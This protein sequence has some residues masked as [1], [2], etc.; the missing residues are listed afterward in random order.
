MAGP[1][2]QDL[3]WLHPSA[4]LGQ[5][6]D[7]TL[8][9][10]ASPAAIHLVERPAQLPGALAALRASLHGP[11]PWVAIDLEWRTDPHGRRS[12]VALLQLASG[13]VCLLVRTCRVPLSPQ[14]QS[15]LR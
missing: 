3:S 11:A 12:H 9:L 6:G 15:F 2:E 7:G 14:L 1:E 10:G 8:R 13:S 4:P 5:G